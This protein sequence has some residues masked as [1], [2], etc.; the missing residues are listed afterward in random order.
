MTSHSNRIGGSSLYRRVNCPGSKREE[1]R[2]DSPDLGNDYADEGSMLHTVME[3]CIE[4]DMPPS[5]AL[6]LDATLLRHNDA[7]FSEETLPLAAL[8]WD[9][10][11]ELRESVEGF[12]KATEV[13]VSL[14]AIAPNLF[15]TADLLW[16]GVYEGR[17]TFGVLDWKFGAGVPVPAKGSHQLGFYMLGA[18]LDPDFADLAAEA[19]QFALSIAQ[20]ARNDEL[21]TWVASREWLM[22][23]RDVIERTNDRLDDPD[24]PLK[25]GDWCRWCSALASCSATASLGRD[26]ISLKPERMT[27]VEYEYWLPLKPII[28]S[29]LNKIEANAE[30]EMQAGCA[31]GGYKIIAKQGRR[32]HVDPEVSYRWLRER[33][34]MLVREINPRS[35]LSPAQVEKAIK[36]KYDSQTAKKLIADFNVDCIDTI[37]SGT[38][39]APDSHPAPALSGV[40]ET[41]N[42]ALEGLDLDFQA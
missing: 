7:R 38:K 40:G 8:A 20:P 27:A 39:I 19:E 35:L 13:R 31:I 17:K 24:A 30:A 15:G 41:L 4:E 3:W 12:V 33:A 6:E 28:I 29:M 25:I 26:V 1:D 32:Q 11:C 9:W 21:D 18:M 2:V 34:K 10:Y 37:S 42:R 36:A 5:A 14:E 22:Q 23:L 16:F